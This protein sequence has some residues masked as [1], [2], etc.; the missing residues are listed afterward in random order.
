MALLGPAP[1]A[2]IGV[3]SVL[4]DDIARRRSLRDT[5]WNAMTFVAFPL[6]GGWIIRLAT[7]GAAFGGADALGFAALVGLVYMLMNAANFGSVALYL[8]LTRGMRFRDSWQAVYVT[9]LPFEFA[10][11]LLTAARRVQ[12]QPHRRRR[13]RPARR[14]AVRLP[15]PDPRGRA[16]VRARDRA[17]A[18]HEGARVAAGRAALDRAADAVDARRDD[19]APLGR[20]RPLLAR[21]RGACSGCPSASRS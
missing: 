16:G 13:R 12:L 2:A 18:A 19:G 6:A 20:G 21:G 7:A 4:V 3:V 8:N 10:T 5:L 11:A 1:A 9:V 17:H 14:R 15:V